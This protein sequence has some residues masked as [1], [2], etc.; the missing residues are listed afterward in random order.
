[1]ARTYLTQLVAIVRQLC[2]YVTKYQSVI[3]PILDSPEKELFLA[4]VAS[5]NAFM[6]SDIVEQ[7]KND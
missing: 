6:Q 1:M 7:A 3:V 5:C 4:L 2:R